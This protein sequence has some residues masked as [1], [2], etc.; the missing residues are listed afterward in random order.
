MTIKAPVAEVLDG[1]FHPRTIAIVGASEN[2]ESFGYQYLRYLIDSGYRGPIYP[3]T[4]R[5]TSVLG[6]KA[7][8]S[9]NQVP[10]DVDYVI[11][12]INA[13]L[14]I[15]LLHQ[16][17]QKKVKAVHLFTARLGETGDAKARELEKEIINEA[18][19]LGVHLIGPNCMGLYYPKERI[20]F[21]HD[22]CMEPG[23]VG[24]I[25]QSGGIAG[26]LA[27]YAGLR[28]VRFSKVISYGNARD[29]NESDF[30]EY[31]GEDDETQIILMYI[32]GVRDGQR[33]LKTL[34]EVTIAKPV[35]ILKGGRTRA[36]AKS[37]ASHTASVAGSIDTWEVVFRQTG[38]IQARD[39][40]ELTDLAVAF[41]L[42]PPITGKHLGIIGGGGG[43]SVL[44]A[45]EFEEAGLDVAP[46]PKQIKRFLESKSPII[47]EWLGNPVDVSILPAFG[48]EAP[49]MLR[50]M[51]QA[52]D[53][54]L[55]VANVTEDSPY[56]DQLWVQAMENEVDGCLLIAQEKLKPIVV[57]MGNPELGISQIMDWRWQAYFRNRER[58]IN[59]S[60]PVFPSPRRAAAAISKMIK[61]YQRRLGGR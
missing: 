51:A 26:E 40:N 23:T 61:Y 58:L 55:L 29:L 3:V 15:D 27:R 25:V 8:P 52:R 4:P 31:F 44:S 32:E 21:N 59:A 42:L 50:R 48:I 56:H 54:D 41:Y 12:C 6:I 38:A 45:D 5:G 17:V 43:K 46:F 49:E 33:F 11:C 2:T 34:R 1:I 13:S 57:V 47:A 9:L 10:G 24:A 16:C 36:G 37:A 35:I 60:I 22:L 18:Q 20:T 28:G 30:L 7:Y 53:F 39:L 19:K 14:V